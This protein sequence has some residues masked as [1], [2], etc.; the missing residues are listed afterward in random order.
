MDSV[1]ISEL[2]VFNFTAFRLLVCLIN[3]IYLVLKTVTTLLYFIVYYEEDVRGVLCE[4]MKA[5]KYELMG[6]ST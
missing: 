6:K 2:I 3:C 4:R 5:S 1:Y